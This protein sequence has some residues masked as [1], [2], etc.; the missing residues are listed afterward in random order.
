MAEQPPRARHRPDPSTEREERDAFILLLHI[1]TVAEPVDMVELEDEQLG[2]DLAFPPDRL[3]PLVDALA[4]GGY[5]QRRSADRLVITAKGI[6]Y[7]RSAR[8][9]RSVRRPPPPRG[10]L[11]RR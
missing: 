1:T 8:N 4:A 3:A 5:V 10:L 2:R 9:R 6:E 11:F 7:I